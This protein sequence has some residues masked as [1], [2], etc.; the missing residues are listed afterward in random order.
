MSADEKVCRMAAAQAPWMAKAMILEGKLGDTGKTMEQWVSNVIERAMVQ[1]WITPK[2]TASSEQLAHWR[3]PTV[4]PP[5]GIVG[6]TGETGAPALE[7]DGQWALAQ[8]LEA[9]FR[10]GPAMT[11]APPEC[12]TI[13]EQTHEAAGEREVARLK[14]VLE[15]TA[16]EKKGASASSIN[17]KLL[18]GDARLE[19]IS[20]KWNQTH[21]HSPAAMRLVKWENKSKLVWECPIDTPSR[22]L[23]GAI[24]TS[25]KILGTTWALHA[26]NLWTTHGLLVGIRTNRTKPSQSETL[27]IVG[28]LTEALEDKQTSARGWAKAFLDAWRKAK[29]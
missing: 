21:L 14:H 19:A 3:W 12:A 13:A 28:A 17:A 5:L 10:H 7:T 18:S 8:N 29:V 26:S 23:A 16:G 25:P 2:I 4:T 22:L 9:R 20:A 15:I 24:N 1:I 27:K 6:A 11:D